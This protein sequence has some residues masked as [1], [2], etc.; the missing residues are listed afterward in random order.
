MIWCD[1]GINF[2]TTY[3]CS[4]YMYY[5]LKNAKDC[6]NLLYT[7]DLQIYAKV[8]SIV[9]SVNLRN[10]WCQQYNRNQNIV[11]Y[12]NNHHQRSFDNKFSEKMFTQ[13]ILYNN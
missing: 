4:I 3:R 13:P 10:N 1:T 7:D 12:T 2:E 5:V 9:D 11:S 8:S 6:K